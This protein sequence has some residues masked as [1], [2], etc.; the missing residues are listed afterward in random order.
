MLTAHPKGV[1]GAVART[2][3]GIPNNWAGIR[4]KVDRDQV[5]GQLLRSKEPSIRWKTR[6]WILEEDPDSRGLRRLQQE[7]AAAPRTRALL[8]GRKRPGPRGVP[9][10]VYHKWLGDHWALAHLAE[11]GYPPG[12]RAVQPMVERAVEVWLRPSY[13]REWVAKSAAETYRRVN[14]DRGVPCIRGRHRRC[15]SQQGNALY[16]ATKLGLS[17]DA[18]DRLAERLIHW[19]WPDGGWNCD[20]NPSADTSSFGETLTPMRGL[21]AYGLSRRNS[22]ARK[23]ALRASEV[24]L[25]RHLY[26]RTS[27]GRIIH[28]EFARLHYPL[29]WHYDILG[30]LKVLSRL[31]LAR[32][33]RCRDALDLLEAKEL[34][35]GGWPAEGRYY[36]LPGQAPRRGTDRVDWESRGP[37]GNEWVTVDALS[38]LRAAGR[39]TPKS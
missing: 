11:L 26:R 32:D 16:Y 7:V 31:G 24:F 22:A 8:Q 35:G 34:P 21:S 25:R 19:Q 1:A 20:R 15:A 17:D 2:L 14:A 37:V 10:G 6:T 12:D 27:D 9:L 5:V 23:A 39:F 18:C 4:F 29:Y 38:V 3:T 33:A 36:D 28:W 30:A 13:F